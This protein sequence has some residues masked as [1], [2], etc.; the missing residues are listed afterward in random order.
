MNKKAPGLGQKA[1]KYK[2]LLFGTGQ[3]KFKKRHGRKRT[4]STIKKSKRVPRNIRRKR[5]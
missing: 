4:K 3:R 1:L 5:T 2:K